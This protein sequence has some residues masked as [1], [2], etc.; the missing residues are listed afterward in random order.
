MADSDSPDKTSPE[1]LTRHLADGE[2]G[3][4]LQRDRTTYAVAPHLPCGMVT[5]ELLRRLADVAERYGCQALKVTSAER[6][7]LIGLQ[8]KD[9]DAVWK[10]LGLTAGG[11]IGDRVRSVRVCAGMQFCKRAQQDSIG[12]G[13]QVD[14]EYHGKPM[15]SKLKIGISA[16]PNQCAETSTKDIGLVGTKQG[17]D[18]LVGGSGGVTPCLGTRI[19][20]GLSTDEAKAMLDGVIAFYQANARPRERLCRTL[21]RVGLDSLLDALGLPRPEAAKGDAANRQISA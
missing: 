21:A 12:I 1:A 10:D 4:V 3:A 2:K 20:R 11:L 7:A 9:I 14:R 19:A 5:P 18:V 15:P 6:I 17:W 16:C 8:E 13:M